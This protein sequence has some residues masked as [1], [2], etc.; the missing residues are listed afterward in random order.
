M[1]AQR[2]AIS[3]RCVAA[4]AESLPF[5]DKRFDAAMAFSTVHHW[6]DPI[7]GLR[8]MQRVAGSDAIKALTSIPGAPTYL[9]IRGLLTAAADGGRIS[10][11]EANAIHSEMRR[12]GFWEKVLPFPD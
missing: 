12:L 3:A 10:R 1:R 8:E 2:P 7:A 6:R 9:R 4:M 5:E 11:S